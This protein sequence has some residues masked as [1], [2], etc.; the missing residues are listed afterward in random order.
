MW[1]M[2]EDRVLEPHRSSCVAVTRSQNLKTETKSQTAWSLG[3]GV[4][5]GGVG[6]QA[7][8]P[9]SGSTLSFLT[10]RERRG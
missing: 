6:V 2:C 7:G 5:G 10:L 8:M 3:A 1:N 4:G 9:I